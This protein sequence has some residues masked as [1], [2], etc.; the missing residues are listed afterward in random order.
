MRTSQPAKIGFPELKSGA[1]TAKPTAATVE[2]MVG[3]IRDMRANKVLR[4]ERVCT[5]VRSHVAC[6]SVSCDEDG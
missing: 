4:R 3:E 1:T 2:H 5:V 6:S